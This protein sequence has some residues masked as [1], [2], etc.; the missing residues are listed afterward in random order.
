MPPQ[1]LVIAGPNGSGKSTLTAGLRSDSAFPSVYVNADDIARTT[2]GW[3]PNR[4]RVVREWLGA[5]FAT[6]KRLQLVRAQTDFAFETVLSTPGKLAILQSA[7]DAGYTVVVVFVATLDAAINRERVLQRVRKGGHPVNADKVEQRY[8][9]AMRLSPCLFEL[10]DEVYVYDNSQEGVEPVEALT[11]HKGQAPV[12][13]AQAPAWVTSLAA[14][15]GVRSNA[16]SHMHGAFAAQ[17]LDALQPNLLDERVYA[18][19]I[20]D[21]TPEFAAQDSGQVGVIHDRRIGA[22]AKDV[23]VGDLARIRY[24]FDAGGKLRR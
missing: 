14:D 13:V 15:V 2:F 20:V 3:L 11:W 17:G 4:F 18:G 16:W 23:K 9:R 24:R 5:V 21:L 8:H 22:V 12:C 6:R 10:C 7:K 1:L 19:T